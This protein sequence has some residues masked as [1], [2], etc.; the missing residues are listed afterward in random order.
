MKDNFIDLLYP[1]GGSSIGATTFVIANVTW[2]GLW[3]IAL[4]AAVV[5]LVGGLI[6][7]AV[8]RIMDALFKDK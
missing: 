3:E 1:V 2:D 7:W 6:G 5:A 8:K 4:Q